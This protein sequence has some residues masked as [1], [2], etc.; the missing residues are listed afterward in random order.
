MAFQIQSSET[1]PEAIRRILHEEIDTAMT[2][3][4]SET[5]PHEGV[6]DARKCFKKIRA[7][8]RLVRDEIGKE[9]FLRENAW[10]RDSGRKLAVLR[11]ATAMMETIEKIQEQFPSEVNTDVLN[12]LNDKLKENHEK[13]SQQYLVEKNI[14]ETVYI[15]LEEGKERVDN[16][17]LEKNSFRA[18]KKSLR[19][20]YLAGYDGMALALDD[21]SD[22]NLH[23]WRKNVKYLWYHMMLLENIWPGM[24]KAFAFEL[25]QLAD[26]LGIDHDLAILSAT[27]EEGQLAIREKSMEDEL[28]MIIAKYRHELQIKIFSLASN[29]Y[30]PKP[31]D[32]TGYL[33]T[34]WN[35]WRRNFPFSLYP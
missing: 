26:M 13:I 35:N 28:Q 25:D 1:L 15:L 10:Y 12:R 22:H 27:L 14:R 24:M 5:D 32:F 11:D 23:E 30:R 33:E 9:S 4:Q 17:R 29:I 2:A 3:L 31:G 34:Y 19:R 6:H 18:I 8:I 16:L 20:I 21:P 7:I